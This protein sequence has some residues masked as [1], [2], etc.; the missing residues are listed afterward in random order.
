MHFN[1]ADSTI[2]EEAAMGE[3]RGIVCF[4]SEASRCTVYILL[5]CTQLSL[6]RFVF[7]DITILPGLFYF[8]PMWTVY[9]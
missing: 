1:V 2:L 4:Y 3:C 6:K 7:S 8:K 9:L 5:L